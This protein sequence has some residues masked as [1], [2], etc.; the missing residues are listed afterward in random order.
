MRTQPTAVVMVMVSTLI[1]S[2]AQ[3]MFKYASFSLSLDIAALITNHYLITGIL[4]YA[5]AAV[6][7]I[8]ALKRGELSVL[9]PLIATS[10]IWVSLMSPMF[11]PAD[12]MN[13]VK[14]AGIAFII[15]GITF[16][17]IGGKHD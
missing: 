9:Y 10:Y 11:F 3:L 1:I 16:V 4:L 15:A 13:A 7:L 12:S 5:V 2:I 8:V 17:G 6:L 14:W